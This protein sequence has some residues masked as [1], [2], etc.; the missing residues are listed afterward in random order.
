MKTY[1]VAAVLASVFVVTACSS[2]DTET[3]VDELVAPVVDGGTD[4]DASACIVD[5]RCGRCIHTTKL[6][7][8]GLGDA[9][10]ICSECGPDTCPESDVPCAS[11]GASCAI[12]DAAGVCT[13][14]CSGIDGMLRCTKL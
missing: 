7:A 5:D 1:S 13:T 3:S 14:C 11:Y 6:P 4:S 9:V 8:I 10:V 12:G 2:G